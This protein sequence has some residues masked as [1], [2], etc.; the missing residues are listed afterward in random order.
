MSTQA[1]GN[2]KVESWDEDGYAETGE[3]GK[4][5]RASVK[6]RFTGDIQGEGAVEY[7]MAYRENETAHFVGLQHVAGRLGDRSGEF[8][9]ETAGTFDGQVAE[10]DW[11][12]VPGSGTGDLRGLRGEGGFS[13]P[14]GPD[15]TVTLDYD[16]D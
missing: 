2:F 16:F 15:A 8:V 3:G 6:Q 4:L 13:A 5:T 10:G 1:R 9:L 12:V 11:K 14:H 7:L